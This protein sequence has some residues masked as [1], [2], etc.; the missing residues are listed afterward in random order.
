MKTSVITG[1]SGNIG[2]AIASEFAA[3][4]HNLVLQYRSHNEPLLKFVAN[5]PQVKILT[6]QA[7]LATDA[8]AKKVIDLACAEFG[9]VDTVV[10]NAGSYTETDEWTGSVEVWKKTL[11]DNLISMLAVSKYAALQFQKQHA[12]CLVNIASRKAV[13]GHYEELAYSA[14]KAGVLNATVSYAKLLSPFARVNA[15]CPGAVESGY[16]LNAPKKELKN[17]INNTAHK[18]L[19]NPQE[20]AAVV[21][22]FA[23]DAASMVTGQYLLVDGGNSLT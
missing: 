23:S 22:F 16:W 9:T 4:G 12:G 18:R 17:H 7:D 8:G 15:V 20:V 11:D 3:L 13:F 6:V 21:A 19:I 14:A 1:S 2:L 10:N 5:H